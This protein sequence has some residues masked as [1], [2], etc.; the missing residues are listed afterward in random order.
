MERI[1]VINKIKNVRKN[2]TNMHFSHF[3]I[4]FSTTNNNNDLGMEEDLDI[5][6]AEGDKLKLNN[7]SSFEIELRDGSSMQPCSKARI[8]YNFGYYSFLKDCHFLESFFYLK[9]FEGFSKGRKFGLKITERGD[10][11]QVSLVP[12][13]IS[14]RN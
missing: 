8:I 9:G 10:T 12:W 3:G 13:S 11:L 14:D 7:I 2:N 1:I 5:L 4:G 6:E